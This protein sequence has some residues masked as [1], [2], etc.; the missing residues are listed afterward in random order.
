MK[1]AKKITMMIGTATIILST[2]ILAQTGTVNAPSGLVLRGEPEKGG[3]IITTV[4]DDTKVEI[5]EKSGD[6]YKVK[7]DGDEGYLF[8]EYVKVE[9]T[10][11]PSTNLDPNTT[12]ENPATNETPNTTTEKP[13]ENTNTQVEVPE[14]AVGTSTQIKNEAKIYIMPLISST[15]IGTI[16]VGTTIT[17]EKT[18]TNWSY[19]KDGTNEGWIRTYL[20][21][22]EV[23]SVNQVT[24]EQPEQPT[25]TKKPDTPPTNN[26]QETPIAKKGVVNVDFA[27]VRKEASQTSEVVTTLARGAD[28]EINAETEEWYKITYTGTDESV[29]EGYIAKRLVKTE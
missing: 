7:Y 22:G 25:D 8:A 16:A 6:W 4:E 21:N 3:S 19:V 15:P 1:K 14:V 18:I 2:T 27:N 13:I 5:I 20:I 24:P 28:I 10:E 11:T 9:E 23:K 17:V 26:T 29:Y 12:T